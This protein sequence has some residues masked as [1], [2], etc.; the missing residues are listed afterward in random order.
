MQSLKNSRG[1]VR[2][3]CPLYVNGFLR[4]MS[5]PVVELESGNTLAGS[6]VRRPARATL[7]G[8]LLAANYDAAQA[9]LQSW[10][11]FLS[12]G[13]L[14][15]RLRDGGPMLLVLPEE[16]DD[17]GTVISK[18]VRFEV[19]LIAVDPVWQGNRFTNIRN[20]TASSTA[21]TITNDGVGVRPEIIIQGSGSGASSSNHP[22]LTNTVTGQSLEYR[23]RLASGQTLTIDC[24]RY[25]AKLGN[26][27]V[28]NSMSEEFLIGGFSLAPGANNIV[29]QRAADSGNFNLTITYLERSL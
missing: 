19:P 21:M 2:N 18:A 11:R 24:E 17:S 20:I 13:P 28:L 5:V 23:G 26:V 10:M 16:L 7:R 29:V 27:G 1:E 9:V 25:T 3:L 6:P 12:H 8:T 22:K 15:L 14:E 4:P